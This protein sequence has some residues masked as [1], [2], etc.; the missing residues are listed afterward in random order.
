MTSSD[1]EAEARLQ[2]KM[3]EAKETAAKKLDFTPRRTVPGI[4][5]YHPGTGHVVGALGADTTAPP[6]DEDETR[7]LL[8]EIQ[9]QG[10]FDDKEMKSCKGT[11]L[12]LDIRFFINGIHFSSSTKWWTR[13][14]PANALCV[15]LEMLLV[16]QPYL[17]DLAL[18]PIPFFDVHHMLPLEVLCP[19]SRIDKLGSS[20]PLLE[21]ATVSDYINTPIAAAEL[22]F[23]SRA[24]ERH[25]RLGQALLERRHLMVLVQGGLH[26][27]AKLEPKELPLDLVDGVFQIPTFSNTLEEGSSQPLPSV[28]DLA[29]L[30]V[31]IQFANSGDGS[32]SVADS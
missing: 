8:S 6:L 32:L 21:L 24:W 29:S 18:E 3:K 30:D 25:Q 28:E 16:L 9:I 2:E 23:D 1:T 11:R 5:L 7:R 13:N 20:S 12:R 14:R 17:T 31:F 27:L 10:G 26:V 15:I 4:A 19:V 22:F